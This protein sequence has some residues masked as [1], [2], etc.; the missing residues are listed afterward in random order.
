M[1]GIILTPLKIINLESG[2]VMHGM[3]RDDPGYCDFGEAYFSF[4]RKGQIKG[5]KKHK[6]MTL[7]LMVP[8]G[9]VVFVL[10]DDRE[11]SKT[12]GEFLEVEL[13]RNNYQRLTVPPNICMGF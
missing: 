6:I 5:W 1:E 4:I 3:K 2:N 11:L 12:K 10:Y 7:N 9:R 13:S 8:L